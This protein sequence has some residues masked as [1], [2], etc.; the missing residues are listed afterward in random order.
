MYM[1]ADIIHLSSL[2][3]IINKILETQHW[4]MTMF[5]KDGTLYPISCSVF[6]SI[7]HS[8][9][10]STNGFFSSIN[11]ATYL[12]LWVIWLS[13]FHWVDFIYFSSKYLPWRHEY[14]QALAW[15]IHLV[16]FSVSISCLFAFLKKHPSLLHLEKNIPKEVIQLNDP[17]KLLRRYQCM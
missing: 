3:Y 14:L 2:Y 12:V 13:Y 7:F 1:V 10:W 11:S 9:D 4:L 17:C 16:M 15:N 6:C 5:E 8:T